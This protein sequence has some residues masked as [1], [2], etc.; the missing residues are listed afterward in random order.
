MLRVFESGRLLTLDG[1]T[2][3]LQRK[4]EIKR[5]P[6][7]NQKRGD[8]ADPKVAG[9]CQAPSFPIT[10]IRAGGLQ[11]GRNCAAG[12]AL[13]LPRTTPPHACSSFED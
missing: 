5:L 11:L 9:S 6:G 3:V 10:G 1:L 7:R 12:I 2:A 4:R 13:G 8:L